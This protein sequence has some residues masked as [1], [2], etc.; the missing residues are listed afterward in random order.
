M[1]LLQ[2]P[3]NSE[4]QVKQDYY[5][6]LRKADNPQYLPKVVSD[7]IEVDVA[8]SFNHMK[9]VTSSNLN[10]ILKAYATVNSAT[11]DY[12]QGMNFIAGFLFM[13]FNQRE[14][15]AFAVLKEII[16]RFSM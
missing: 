9:D 16:K 13:L 1:R 7:A 3:I 5:H 15:M 4:E 12:C 6:Y 10:N 2:I 14:D 11:L 8:R